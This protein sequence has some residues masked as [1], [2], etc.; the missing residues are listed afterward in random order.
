MRKP[1]DLLAKGLIL[2]DSRG[3]RIRTYDPLVPNQMDHADAT[4]ENVGN[5]SIAS[6]RCTNGCTCD[7]CL[8]QLAEHL[9]SVLDGEQ[10]RRLADW[11]TD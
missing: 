1:F 9:R 10:R 6:E 3:D 4:K 2:K 8:M 11:L 5:S 7:P